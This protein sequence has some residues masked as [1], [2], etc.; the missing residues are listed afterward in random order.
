MTDI[1]VRGLSLDVLTKIDGEA[2]RR[3]LSRNQFLV[4][5]LESPYVEQNRR[6]V[7][8]ADLERSAGAVADLGNPEIMA[9]AWR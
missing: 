8:V 4:D 6:E 9:E 3:G 1:L 5:F 2:S 7:T